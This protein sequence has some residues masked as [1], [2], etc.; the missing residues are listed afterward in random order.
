MVFFFKYFTLKMEKAKK[1]LYRPEKTLRA[2]G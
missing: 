2:P 1:S